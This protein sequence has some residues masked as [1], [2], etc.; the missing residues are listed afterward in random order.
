LICETWS[1]DTHRIPKL[2]SKRWLRWSTTLDLIKI[3]EV[4]KLSQTTDARI[5]SQHFRPTDYTQNKKR[6]LLR[7]DAVPTLELNR[8]AVLIPLDGSEQFSYLISDS[9]IHLIET[10]T[11]FEGGEVEVSKEV[12]EKIITTVNVLQEQTEALEAMN[13]LMRELKYCNK[14]NQ[15]IM[16]PF[17]KG[18]LISNRSLVELLSDVKKE[19]KTYLLAYR[20]Q[21]DCIENLFSQVRAC[22]GFKSHPSPLECLSRLKTITLIK[23]PDQFLSKSANVERIDD[24]QSFLHED[25]S[26][27]ISSSSDIEDEERFVTQVHEIEDTSESSEN[28]DPR[29]EILSTSPG[30]SFHEKAK[31]GVLNYIAGWCVKKCKRSKRSHL[32]HKDE[33]VLIK[34][35]SW[36]KKMSKDSRLTLPSKQ[37]MFQTNKCEQIFLRY[38]KH[39]IVRRDPFSLTSLILRRHPN[40]N[41]E[42]VANFVKVRTWARIK[43]FNRQI[44]ISKLKS[45]RFLKQIRQHI[46]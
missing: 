27:S 10:T 25:Q 19:G 44:K 38:H 32:T 2:Y 23:S 5:C 26:E 28:E 1:Y 35:H 11:Q 6:R 40:F 12:E 4:W 29:D 15:S 41:A 20:T 39:E 42:V 45:L 7:S 16:K 30:S 33:T 43:F 36:I 17:Q 22:Y 3:N 9:E 34:E 31:S 13:E 18:I 8:Y 37:V 46:N 14:P 24:Q 21:Q